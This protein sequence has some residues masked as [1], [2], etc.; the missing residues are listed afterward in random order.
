MIPHWTIPRISKQSL[1]AVLG[2]IK[3]KLNADL[4]AV[5]HV[6]EKN[7]LFHSKGLISDFKISPFLRSPIKADFP[8][9]HGMSVMSAIL[10]CHPGMD[11]LNFSKLVINSKTPT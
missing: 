9:C 4:T 11:A 2:G 5:T 3:A 8:Y 7:G 6:I 1:P 10:L